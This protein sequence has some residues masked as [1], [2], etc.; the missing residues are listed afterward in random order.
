MIVHFSLVLL[1]TKAM[2][3]SARATD[4]DFCTRHFFGAV[5]HRPGFYAIRAT[6]PLTVV[7][8]LAG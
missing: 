4:L 7:I 6:T 5:S 8:T 1:R 2:E 3:G